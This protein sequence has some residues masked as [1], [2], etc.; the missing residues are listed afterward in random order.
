MKHKWSFLI[1]KINNL[2]FIISKKGSWDIRPEDNLT[3]LS[4]IY[5][6]VISLEF[7]NFSHN[8][9][10]NAN[11]GQLNIRWCFV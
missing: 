3:L 10:S 4:K 11:Y 1:N 6:I 5:T 2:V 7:I 9:I 8:N